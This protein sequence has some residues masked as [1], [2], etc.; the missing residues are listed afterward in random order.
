MTG[1]SRSLLQIDRLGIAYRASTG[2]AQAVRDVSLNIAAGECLGLVGESGCGKSTIALAIMRYLGAN[3]RQTNGTI[4][5]D[6]KDLAEFSGRD[7]RQLRGGDIAMVF[8]EPFAALNPT[9]RIGAQILEVPQ[10]HGLW[11]RRE[12][13]Q[14]ALA[15][16]T[17]VH[18]P[19]PARVMTAYPHE[20]S[21]GQLQRVVI[22][23]ALLG[24][25]RLLL[26]DEPTTALDPTVE[27]G[28]MEIIDE[29]RREM[30]TAL[31]FI[32]H[33]LALV[34][35]V[36]D[37]I[38]VM[39]AGEIVEEGPV[40]EFFA[41]PRHPYSR[42][43]LDCVPHP[44]RPPS[45]VPLLAIPGQPPAL[46]SRIP[47]CQF[48]P[49]C[50]RFKPG[51]CDT[52]EPPLLQVHEGAVRCARWQEPLKAARPMPQAP[53]TISDDRAV[54][55]VRA[56]KRYTISQ[57]RFGGGV[58]G[59]VWAN[60]GISLRAQ[61]GETLAI[62]GE[63]GCGKSTLAKMLAGLETASSGEVRI[64][65]ADVANVR[66]EDRPLAIRRG[67][68]MVFQNPSDTLN[69]AHTIGMQ[70]SRGLRKLGGV[71]GRQALEAGVQELLAQ[72]KLPPET[73][74]RYP[75]QL[76]GGQRQRVAIARALASNPKIIVAD[77]P[78]SALDVSVQAAISEL[79]LELRR[80]HGLT[81]IFVSHDL[82]MVRYLADHVV[83]MY[84]GRVMEMG[85]VQEIFWPPYHPYTETLLSAAP[86]L[87]KG[88]ETGRRAM[89]EGAPASPAS[90]QRGCPFAARCPRKVGEICDTEVPPERDAWDGHMIACHI[91]LEDLAKMDPVY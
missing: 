42:G 41:A 31:L 83:V 24:S 34:R 1:P 65:G 36:S 89:V 50:S 64:L 7:L 81:L 82:G 58:Q 49:R 4:R 70:L 5:F 12:T 25:P 47:G 66:V 69:P 88:G 19:D 9:M 71:K 72:V 86:S 62:V 85:A 61:G 40:G 45:E 53:H 80:T 15:M 33:N 55:L 27:A 30:G 14:Q 26:M 90:Q 10:A 28:I 29:V 54:E 35:R 3:G 21:G 48:A 60:D 18:L 11:D 22:A 44:N 74:A 77:E 17:R 73:A 84:L 56:S 76:S 57:G 32:S 87:D 52:G 8:Q 43:L 6:G 16:L 63:S 68:Q 39:Y 37:R 13:R 20:L 67:L 2:T 79:L 78:L 51:I 75:R 59:E 91:P 38:A 46:T 23:M